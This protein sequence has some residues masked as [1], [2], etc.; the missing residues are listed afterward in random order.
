VPVVTHNAQ[1]EFIM[2][3]VRRWYV[4]LV[5]AVSL[6]SVTWAVIAQVTD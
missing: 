3:T 6:Q 1:K 5:C 4:F 2:V